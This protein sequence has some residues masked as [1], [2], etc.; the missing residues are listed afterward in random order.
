EILG[1]SSGAGAGGG[2]TMP[3]GPHPYK[4]LQVVTGS[5]HSC[6]LLEDHRVKCWGNNLLGQLGLGDTKARGLDADG[7]GDALPFVDLGNGRTAKQLA[8]GYQ[9]SCAVLDDDSVKCWGAD[10]FA[11]QQGTPSVLGDQPGEMGDAL[12][13]VALGAGHHGGSVAVGHFS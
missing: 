5:D 7:M 13:T 9:M 10:L 4:T 3:A 12:P 8:A 1:G 2:P 11:V 6:A